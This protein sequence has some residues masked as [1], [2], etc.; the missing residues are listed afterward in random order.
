MKDHFGFTHSLHSLTHFTHDMSHKPLSGVNPRI[1]VLRRIK[2][3]RLLPTV[4]E[5][6]AAHK[7]A[8]VIANI[9]LKNQPLVVPAPVDRL[10]IFD[11]ETTRVGAWDRISVMFPVP[12]QDTTVSPTWSRVITLS[13]KLYRFEWLFDIWI[14]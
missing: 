13:S 3:R 14:F 12:W 4:N 5:M 8:V 2:R 7:N 10:I 1:I 11:T 6:M 9:R